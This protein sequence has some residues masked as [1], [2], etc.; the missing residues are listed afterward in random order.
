MRQYIHKFKNYTS[1]EVDNLHDLKEGDLALYEDKF[2][3]RN[4]GKVE[5]VVKGGGGSSED[6]YSTDYPDD[7]YFEWI[8]DSSMK[9][10]QSFKSF[11]NTSAA[12]FPAETSEEETL[13]DRVKA[14]VV[15]IHIENLNP[16][17]V[18]CIFTLPEA[19]KTVPPGYTS[20]YP[21]SETFPM[22]VFLTNKSVSHNYTMGSD[23]DLLLISYLWNTGGHGKYS[24][25]KLYFETKDGKKYKTCGI[26]PLNFSLYSEDI[27][28]YR[29]D[30]SKE[31]LTLN[32]TLDLL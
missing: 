28:I 1:V 29:E 24:F 21:L 27:P 25:M 32:P 16:K 15:H 5:E 13:P 14:T 17:S 22:L 11:N 30:N 31:F 19:S 4:N 6:E 10:T 9:K 20:A 18:K 26:V 12:L 23:S 8:G 3:T 2:L 7:F